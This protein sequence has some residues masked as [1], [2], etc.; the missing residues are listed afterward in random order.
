MYLEEVGTK[1][2]QTIIFLHGAGMSGWVWQK[3]I[4]YFKD[5]HCLIPDLPGHGKSHEPLLSLRDCAE[6]VA[7]IIE[8]RADKKVHVVGHSL[9]ARVVIELLSIKP[10][11]VDHAII[12]SALCRPMK[13]MSWSNRLWVYK[14]SSWLCQYKKVLQ[15]LSKLYQFPDQFYQQNFIKDARRLTAGDLQNIYDIVY[16]NLKLPQGLSNVKTSVLAMAGAKEP[17]AMRQSVKDLAV[18]LPNSKG[19]LVR[20]AKHTL[21]WAEIELFN[22]IIR[23]W[24]EDG[25][26]ESDLVYEV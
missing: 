11:F 18:A 25:H 2:A 17:M 4:E 1:N 21:P 6:K 15:L 9:G 12:V 20:G 5:Y 10:E 7:E 14:L 8:T 23:S 22:K 13:I 24:I 16:Q 19:I 3:Q 26:L